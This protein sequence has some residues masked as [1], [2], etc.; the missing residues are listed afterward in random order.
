MKVLDT[1]EEAVQIIKSGDRVFIHSAAATP[2]TLVEA[3]SARHN[4]LKG[5]EIVSLHTEGPVPYAKE[6]Y[7]DSFTINSFFVG[8]NIRP[9]IQSG[10]ANYIPI[11]LAEIPSLFKSGKM[12]LDVALVTVSPPNKKG[13][14]SLGCSVDVSNSAID[15]AKHVIAQINPNMPFVHGNGIISVEKIDT[16]VYVD[17][18]LYELK[19]HESDETEKAI[20]RHVA[21][22]VEDGATLQMGIGGIPDAAL[23]YLTNHKNLGVHT[24]MCSDG[25][26][27]LVES[28]VING[29]NKKTE[30]GKIV[31][32]FAYGTRK[33]YD[34]I[35]ENPIVN[36][37]DVGY[38]N[39]TKVIRQNPK[40]TAINSAIEIDVFGQVCADSIGPRH[41]S[42]IG[43]QM[44]FIRGAA[45]SEGGKAII[46]L[47]SQTKKGIPR[48]VSTLKRGAPVVT[49]RA[50]VQ[51]IITEYG[52]VN[53]YGKNLKERAKLM[54]GLAHPDDREN[55][56][57]EV[58]EIYNVQV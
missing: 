10:R 18:P 21:E 26:V 7:A 41:Y 1:A 37:M 33:I 31:A 35:D 50:H 44:D 47:P 49:T 54:I 57:K 25:I 23:K 11:F 52:R 55:L 14:C 6:E 8:K 45:L 56:V 51:H 5:V 34:F 22:L 42:G 38:T 29:M 12:P 9:Y 3:M 4:E 39:D 53:L 43:G 16:A 28:G 46:A 13:Y 30:F 17:T 15:N 24:E 27:D 19:P 36:M 32:G 48:I 40:V 20:G 2:T 58:F